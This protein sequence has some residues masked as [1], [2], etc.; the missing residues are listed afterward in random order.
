MAGNEIFNAFTVIVHWLGGVASQG[1]GIIARVI[2]RTMN[3]HGGVRKLS[4]NLP[5][6]KIML[7]GLF[8][9]SAKI[10]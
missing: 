8:V 4:S 5:P 10:A 3:P 6:I 1:E 7:Y 9:L 2:T